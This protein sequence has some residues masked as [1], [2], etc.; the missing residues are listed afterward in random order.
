[1]SDETVKP[2]PAT[3]RLPA[4]FVAF[5]AFCM[6]ACVVLAYQV[7]SLR[8]EVTRLRGEVAVRPAQLPEA[9]TKAGGGAVVVGESVPDLVAVDCDGAAV[10]VN[11]SNALAF[12]DGRF[13]TIMLATSGDCDACGYSLPAFDVLARENIATGVTV[14]GVQIN[15]MKGE[16][17]K[18]SPGNL[19][20]VMVPDAANSW[21]RRIPMVPAVIVIDGQGAVRQTWFGTLSAAQQEEL[22][23]TVRKAQANWR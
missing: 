7:V 13:A 19:P 15:A 21:L 5:T 16:E 22:A 2:K 9:M 4:T 10:L 8:R 17:L 18:S 12:R 3:T 23:A 20:M 1:M 14:V 6:L 11:G